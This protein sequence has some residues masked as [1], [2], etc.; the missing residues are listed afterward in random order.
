MCSLP[1]WK[2]VCRK[3]SMDQC[4]VSIVHGIDQIWKVRPEL[5]RSQ[6]SFVDDRPATQGTNIEPLTRRW[7]SMTGTFA[8]NEELPIEFILCYGCLRNDKHLEKM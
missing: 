5:I 3:P 1:T 7:N 6:L 4:Q 2:R 8:K